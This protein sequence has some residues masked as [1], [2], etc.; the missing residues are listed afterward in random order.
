MHGYGETLATWKPYYLTF[1]LPSTEA[2]R[3][4][5][6]RIVTLQEINRYEA[7]NEMLDAGCLLPNIGGLRDDILYFA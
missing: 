2:R 3:G 6:G 5:A 1:G 4:P 7:N